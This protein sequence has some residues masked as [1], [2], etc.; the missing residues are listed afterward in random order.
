MYKR[1]W[2]RSLFGRN[3]LV[4]LCLTA[5]AQASTI[6]V[7]VLLQ[8]PRVIEVAHLVATQ[9]NTLDAAL[10]LVP[11][12]RLNS[13]VAGLNRTSPL[14][15]QRSRPAITDDEPT[16]PLVQL[17]VRNVRA[18]L[19][20]GIEIRWSSTP[21]TSIWIHV[22]ISG[23]HYW[24]ML[25]VT[26]LLQYRLLTSVLSLSLCMALSAAMGA[27]MIQRRIN[28]PLR[29]LAEAA[30]N[31]GAGGRADRLPTYPVI[32]LASVAEQFNAMMD[33]LEEMEVSR[34]LMLAGISHDIRSPLTKLRLVLAM[35]AH[36][37]ELPLSR[38][39]D[40]IDTVVGQ[41]LDF[42]R[43]GSEEPIQNGDLNGLISRL[44]E[45]FAERGHPFT[46]QLGALPP[47]R[48][49]PVAMLRLVSNLMENAVKYGITGLEIATC[50]EFGV[51]VLAVR[52][53]GPGLPPG[54]ETR[55]LKPFLRGDDGRSQVSGSGLG[56]AIVE[57]IARL[58]G[59]RVS[60]VRRTPHGLEVCVRWPSKQTLTV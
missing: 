21:R 31:V 11:T 26:A 29:D 37:S 10:S 43:T 54:D 55:L 59:G 24:V 23:E 28:R 14:S 58:D 53:R 30:R 13:Y 16:S 34:A 12:D 51:I 39:I 4:L 2:P 25:P 7:Y 42:A 40:Q 27:W 9:V 5:I 1:L 17:F 44:A 47:W 56:L 22:N 45:E 18:N 32:E 19:D 49:R 36:A 50:V 38:Y 57:R 41:F 3:L 60:L 20:P 15:V 33:S 8:R 6:T 46:L 48:F 52:D 35:D